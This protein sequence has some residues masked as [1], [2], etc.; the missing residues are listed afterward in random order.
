M[1]VHKGYFE[2]KMSYQEEKKLFS[3]MTSICDKILLQNGPFLKEGVYQEVLY[4]EL[5]MIGFLPKREV[6]FSS[7]FIDSVGTQVFIG[8]GHSL[9]SDIELPKSNCILELKSS[10]HDTK[11]EHIWQLRNYLEQRPDM[12]FGIV[13]NFISKFGKKEESNPCVQYDLLVKTGEYIIE[14][15]QKIN[16]YYHH[17][18]SNGAKYPSK[19][20]IFIIE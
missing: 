7:Y 8:N 11:E 13:I 17:G 1:N 9:R 15:E 14:E 6:V 19:A 16:K 20:K 4:H 3:L 18:I 5:E 12:K 10:G 2:V